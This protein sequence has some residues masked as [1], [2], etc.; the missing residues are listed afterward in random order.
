MNNDIYNHLKFKLGTEYDSFEF[1]VISIPPYE[2]L[3]NNL[4]LVSYEYFGDTSKILG[5]ITKHIF[6]YFNADILM[7]VE[8]LYRGD[9]V[10][11]IKRKLEE[12]NITFPDNVTLKLFYSI[13]TGLT[14]LMYQNKVLDSFY[15][16]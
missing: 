2:F 7:R 12:L 6:L 16:Y 3:E 15:K 5:F 8:L 14:I 10:K 9:K 11:T 13:G 4:S 1:Q